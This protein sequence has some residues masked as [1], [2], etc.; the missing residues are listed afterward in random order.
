MCNDYRLEVDVASIVEDFAD[1][2]IKIT[3]PEGIPN[4]APRADIKITDVAP[5]VRTGAIRW[6]VQ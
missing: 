4:L 6:S 3:M 5:I 1:L 2:K